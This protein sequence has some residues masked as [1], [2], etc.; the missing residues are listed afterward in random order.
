MSIDNF[1]PTLWAVELLEN[2][3]DKHVYSDLLNRDYEGQINN[4]GDTVKINSIGRI[5]IATY[6]KNSTINAPETLDDSNLM[7][8][9]TESDYF[10]F[11][12]DNID[13]KQ[14]QPK[15]MGDAM[16]EAGWG[17]SDVTDAFVAS[18]L[19]AGVATAAPDNTLAAATVG[20]GATNADAYELLVDLGVKLD[21][22]NCPEDG[23]WVVI[24]PWYH[25]MLLKDPR[26]VSFGTDKNRELLKNGQ[27]G[28]AAGFLI[29]KSNN[30]PVSGS[31]Y[32][33]IAGHKVSASFAEQINDPKAFEPEDSFSDAMKGLHLY[34]AKVTRPY[35]LASVVA[36]SA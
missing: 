20:T 29:L 13:K 24:P 34:G 15:L 23:R 22:S 1:I 10:N 18:L 5:T 35:A 21:E 3:N 6:T 7:L 28:E 27:I 25:G 11:E 16:K 19:E 26:F 30:V 2:L 12:I 8:A 31:A 36:T 14:Q 9:I 4:V 33:V 32:T 17:L